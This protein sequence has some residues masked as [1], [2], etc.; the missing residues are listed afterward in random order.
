MHLYREA[1]DCSAANR[2]LN[3]FLHLSA[4]SI[5]IVAGLLCQ[6]S[7]HFTLKGCIDDV[8]NHRIQCAIFSEKRFSRFDVLK[9]LCLEVY[10]FFHCYCVLQQYFIIFV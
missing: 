10:Y 5:A 4:T 3:L 8:L 9:G 1:S 7:I 6:I 2:C